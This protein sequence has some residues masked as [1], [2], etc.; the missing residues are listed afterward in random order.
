MVDTCVWE[1][2]LFTSRTGRCPVERFLR[3]QRDSTVRAAAIRKI[4]HLSRVGPENAKRPLADTVRGEI[5][6][7]RVDRQVRILFFWH[8]E[9]HVVVCVEAERKKNGGLDEEVIER[10]ARNREEWLENHRS[11][12]LEATARALGIGGP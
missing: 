10:A 5:K 12:S 6:E 4:Q 3:E 7:L 8:R 11:K 1:P 9:D 2:L